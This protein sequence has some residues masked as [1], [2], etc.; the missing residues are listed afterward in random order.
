MVSTWIQIMHIEDGES[1]SLIVIV[2]YKWQNK[3]L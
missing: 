2:K 3:E 1:S